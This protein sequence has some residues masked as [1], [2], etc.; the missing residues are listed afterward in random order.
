MKGKGIEFKGVVRKEV[1]FADAVMVRFMQSMS[2]IFIVQSNDFVK[3]AEWALSLSR[4]ETDNHANMHVVGKNV[5][6][7]T[8]Y[9]WPVNVC[10]LTGLHDMSSLLQLGGG[11]P[12][13]S[14]G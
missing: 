8:H 5:C 2:S 9:K 1:R 10:V 14:R 7:F 12:T 3:V 13:L 11:V 4:S 6:V